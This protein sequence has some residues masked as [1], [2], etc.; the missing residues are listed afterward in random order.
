ML[1]A[2]SYI[3]WHLEFELP[4]HI[5]AGK[6]SVF[7][8]VHFG[9]NFVSL[10]S[11]FVSKSSYICSCFRLF[12]TQRSE[13]LSEKRLFVYSG[14]A[15]IDRLTSFPTLTSAAQWAKWEIQQ[16]T[17]LAC[18]GLVASTSRL[19]H[20]TPSPG[21]TGHQS[22]VH[23]HQ[24]TWTFRSRVLGSMHRPPAVWKC[25]QSG[26]Y[27]AAVTPAFFFFF[28]YNAIV[29]K[30]FMVFFQNK[31]SNVMENLPSFFCCCCI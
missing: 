17:F 18:P 23:T 25:P 9:I 11:F 10:H 14:D 6:L 5:S 29:V 4:Q 13:C 16:P 2:G 21:R 31:S 30:P 27:P 22:C 26:S 3:M 15:D 19:M 1:V 8:N 12:R 24:M 7:L 20:R 28:L